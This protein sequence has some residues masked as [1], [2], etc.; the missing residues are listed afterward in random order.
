MINPNETSTPPAAPQAPETDTAIEQTKRAALNQGDTVRASWRFSLDTIR[1]NIAYMSTEAK[2]L[3]V[4]AFGWCIDDAHPVRF[5]DFCERIG[6]STSVIYKAYSG[7]LRHPT[8]KNADQQPQLMDLSADCVKALRSFRRL[9]LQR[10]KLGSKKFINTPTA[11][12]VF[13]ACD[14]ARESQ[15]PVFIEGASQ[16]GKTEAVK[17]YCLEN[18]HGRSRIIEIDATGGLHALIK[19]TAAV[20]G[21]SINGNANDLTE[22]IKKAITSD[23]VL[24]FDEVHNLWNAHRKASFFI[25]VEWIRRLYDHKQF[26]LVLTF[27]NL[28]FAK[29]EQERKRELEQCFRRGVHRINLGDQPL[30]EDVRMILASWG[31][32]FPARA[33]KCDIVVGGKTIVEEPWKLLKQLGAEQGLKSI[34]ERLRYAA[35]LAGDASRE[36]ITMEDFCRAHLTI[37][38]AAITP[39]TG[40]EEKEAA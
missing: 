15:T 22:R 25:C 9:E 12:R 29:A 31:M 16:I 21:V 33:D 17:Q 28:G 39:K 40:W 8:L 37:A 32:D 24:V 30:V 38:K 5:D 35:K 7:K 34:T 18:N 13:L 4:W 14:L 6:Y 11:K 3:L 23:M 2:E 36:E 10:A 19:A 26:G 20:L 1:S 27:T